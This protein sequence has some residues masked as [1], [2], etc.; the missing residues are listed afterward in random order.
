MRTPHSGL[1]RSLDDYVE[2]ELDYGKVI[3]WSLGNDCP[4]TG[5]ETKKA[6]K[7]LGRI[8]IPFDEILVREQPNK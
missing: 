4:K 1:E 2:Q 7:L 6:K 8:G 3:M 5:K